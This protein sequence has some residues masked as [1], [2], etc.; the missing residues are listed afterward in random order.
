MT[1]TSKFSLTKEE[2]LKRKKLLLSKHNMFCDTVKDTTKIKNSKKIIAKKKSNPI[3]MKAD[4]DDGWESERELN[5][6]ELVMNDSETTLVNAPT[7]LKTPAQTK[8][9]IRSRNRHYSPS[10]STNPSSQHDMVASAV[11]RVNSSPAQQ[12]GQCTKTWQGSERSKPRD[13]E[14]LKEMFIEIKTLWHEL[15]HYEELSGRKSVFHTEV[16][17]PKMTKPHTTKRTRIV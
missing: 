2:I 5:A 3:A 6:L 12:K 17:S 8:S 10:S 16:R 1:D 15:K 13:D 11:E 7:Q 9:H 14:E 4:D